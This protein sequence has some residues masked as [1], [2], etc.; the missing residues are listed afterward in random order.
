MED[1]RPRYKT[2]CP[3]CGKEMY[4]CKSIAMEM[5]MPDLGHGSCWNCNTSLHLEFNEEKQEMIATPWKE[6][7]KQREEKKNNE[8][9]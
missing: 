5:G 1:N 4:V 3:A 8:I 9:L 6:W 7:K 2:I